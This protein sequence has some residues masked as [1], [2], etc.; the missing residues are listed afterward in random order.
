MVFFPLL[1]L[2]LAAIFYVIV[3]V[4]TIPRLRP[5]FVATLG[6]F[7]IAGG[8]AIVALLTVGLVELSSTE[9]VAAQDDPAAT[10]A[11]SEPA[12]ESAV[13]SVAPAATPAPATLP[14][15]RIDPSAAIPLTPADEAKSE[16]LKPEDIKIETLADGTII[17]PAGRP[18]W[19]AAHKSDFS[20]PK[21][22]RIYV[23]SDPHAL[24]QDA[25]KG[26]DQA[27]AKATDEYIG[28]Q[29]HSPLAAKFI[30]YDIQMIHDRFVKQTYRE[31][32]TFAD[33]VGP[34]HQL[35]AQLEFDENFRKEISRTWAGRIAESRLY[36]VGLGA[37]AALLL[38]SSV[39]GYFRLDNAT[40][41]YY[42]GRL[43]FLTAAAILAVIGGG[44]FAARWNHW[45]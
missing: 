10:P 43:Q 45:L 24:P 26:L 19:V 9:L 16:D 40:R 12:A 25:R 13:V 17:I 8:S 38:L 30:H 11:T 1:A 4:V 28:D 41:G 36:Q 33:P 5:L 42:T 23:T 34:M 35:H 21:V 44:V 2:V 22:H 14:E 18:Q 3:R 20:D 39:F 31:T 7:A 37:G 6:W 27:L 15:I 32:V 29:L